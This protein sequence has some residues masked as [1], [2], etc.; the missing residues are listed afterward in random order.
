[1]PADEG[2]PGPF[3]FADPAHAAS[4]LEAAGWTDVRTDGYRGPM[5]FGP[6]PSA[7]FDF[8]STQGF[9][10]FRL[11]ELDTAAR[12]AALAA[13]RTTLDAHHNDDGVTYDSAVWIIHA[14]RP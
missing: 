10:R 14:R 2:A 13:L 9:T 6:D 3:V 1:M 7:A 11:S 5:W 8:V 4:V 12:E